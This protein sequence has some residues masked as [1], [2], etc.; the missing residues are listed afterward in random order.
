M[1]TLAIMIISFRTKESAEYEPTSLRSLSDS[2]EQHLKKK[3]YSVSIINDSVFEKLTRNVLQSEQKQL[4]KQRKG[5]LPNASV[6]MTS[7]I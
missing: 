1:N 7:R 2:F 3:G 4:K 5:N 6:A